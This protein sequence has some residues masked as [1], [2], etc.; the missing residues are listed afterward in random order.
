MERGFSGFALAKG[1]DS[2]A[3]TFRGSRAIAGSTF[4]MNQRQVSRLHVRRY[5]WYVREFAE[6]LRQVREQTSQEEEKV[7]RHAAAVSVA[8]ENVRF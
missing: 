5:C 1:S 6:D 4:E 2:L 7:G 8:N 3:F